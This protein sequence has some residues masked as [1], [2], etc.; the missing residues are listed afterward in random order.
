MTDLTIQ[1]TERMV[2]ANHPTLADTLNR[3]A[4]VEHN[5]DGTHNKLTQVK[6]PYVDVRAYG[7]VGDGVT[8]DTTA[9]QN[10]INSVK[11]NGCGKIFL[12][13]GVWK[14]TSP[15]ELS[16]GVILEGSGKAACFIYNTGNGPA[17]KFVSTVVNAYPQNGSSTLPYYW[18]IRKLAIR[19]DSALASNTGIKLS[20]GASYGLVESVDIMDTGSHAIDMQNGTGSGAIYN[21]FIDIKV[22]RPRGYA[23]YMTGEAS[24]NEFLNF[25]AQHL[26]S[27]GIVIMSDGASPKNNKFFGGGV[28]HRGTGV[29]GDYTI[30]KQGAITGVGVLATTLKGMYLEGMSSSY[31][32]TIHAVKVEKGSLD[33]DSGFISQVHYGIVTSN[34]STASVRGTYFYWSASG[35]PSPQYCFQQIGTSRMQIGE[36]NIRW[37]GASSWTWYAEAVGNSITGF[38]YANEPYH[39][40]NFLKGSHPRIIGATTSAGADTVSF[41]SLNGSG[42]ETVRAAITGYIDRSNFRVYNSNLQIGADYNGDRLL[43]LRGATN[44]QVWVDADGKILQKTSAPASDTDGTSVGLGSTQSTVGAAGGASA[45]PATP[46]G[47]AT[48]RI[49]G[50]EYVM[51]YYA[52]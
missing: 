2:G 10:A 33:M 9:I 22:Q 34:D 27:D 37:S 3:L 4:L 47:Y 1:H 21:T 31:V 50:T 49:A 15:I 28:E 40:Y 7:A 30:F 6:D 16:Y 19:G 12:P 38:I 42:V 35:V 39:F 14:I 52:K 45:L 32:G 24:Q 48:I 41:R 25:H 36:G 17:I 29:T 18:S 8:D 11:A 13:G 5:N 23:L 46:S 44:S 43:L 51:P 26:Y 20:D